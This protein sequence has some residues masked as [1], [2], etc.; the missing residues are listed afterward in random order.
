[1]FPSFLSV[2]VRL[3]GI[4]PARP[5]SLDP[6]SSA[7][8]NSATGAFAAAKLPNIFDMEKLLTRK[9]AFAQPPPLRGSH[10]IAHRRSHRERTAELLPNAA[11][12]HS[13]TREAQNLQPFDYKAIG[14]MYGFSVQKVWFYKAKG[15]VSHS[16]TIPFA[17]QQHTS[18]AARRAKSHRKASTPRHS[19]GIHSASKRRAYSMMVSRPRRKSS[20]VMLTDTS[21][22]MPSSVL[23][24]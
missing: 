2:V 3:T 11:E 9:C 5:A 6:K 22:A 15:M 4:E 19:G 13:G 20:S 21:G 17:Q 24:P 23:R 1:M 10:P 12:K 18:R 14:K 16:E 7:S 8:T